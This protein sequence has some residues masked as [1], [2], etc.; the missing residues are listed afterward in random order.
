LCFL[1]LL[2]IEE[3]LSQ[4]NLKRVLEIELRVGEP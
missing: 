2:T 1:F 4:N 3:K